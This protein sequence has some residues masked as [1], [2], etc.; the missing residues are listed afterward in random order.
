MYNAGTRMAH[1]ATIDAYNKIAEEF[2]KRNTSTDFYAEEY[3]TFYSLVPRGGAVLE[4]GCG[5]GRDA[6]I[7]KNKGFSYTGLDASEGMLTL[8]RSRV[9][10]GNFVLGDFYALP[11]PD[12]HFDAVWAAATFLHVPKEDI[13]MVLGEARR[14]LKPEGSMF[15]SLKE[16][17]DMDEGII[18]EEKGGGIER[19]FAF[20]TEDESAALLRENGFELLHVI[21]QVEHDERHTPWICFFVKKILK[22]YTV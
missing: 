18:T 6:E 11:F 15:L 8:A 13:A 19:Y 3:E 5:P 7:L 4:I 10:D 12:A 20:Y 2:N 1:Q 9:P 21:H 16:R 17:T 14:V 22:D